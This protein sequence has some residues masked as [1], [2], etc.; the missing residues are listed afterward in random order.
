M[1]VQHPRGRRHPS[2]PLPKQLIPRL[3]DIAQQPYRNQVD[4]LSI[5]FPNKENARYQ[6]YLYHDDLPY[7]HIMETFDHGNHMI[8]YALIPRL[9]SILKMEKRYNDWKTISL[10]SETE[11]E[12]LLP[13]RFRTRSGWMLKPASRPQMKAL[14]KLLCLP[15]RSIPELTAYNVQLLLQTTLIMRHLPRVVEMVESFDLNYA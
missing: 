13:D 7:I 11:V 6:W 15:V 2:Q 14:S 10:V 12:S 4:A 9:R 1:K 5:A 3:R 8:L